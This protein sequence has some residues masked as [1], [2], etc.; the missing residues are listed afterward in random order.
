MFYHNHPCAITREIVRRGIKR[1]NLWSCPPCSFDPDLLI[2]AGLVERTYLAYVG[3]EHMGFAPFFRK[4]TENGEID[5]VLCDE[6]TL[7]GALMA[8]IE[9]IPYHP[10]T[11]LRGTDTARL[12]PLAQ[13]YVAPTGDKLMAVRAMSPD[14][15]VLLVTE[16]DEYGN[17]RHMGSV[18]MDLILAKAS[19][20]V[21]L[22][23]EQIV[24]HEKVLAE[25]HRTT[26]PAYLVDMVV[27][28]PWGAHPCSSHM[29]Y[30][31]DEDHMREYVESAKL[32]INGQDP[33]AFP[34]YLKK[35]IYEPR[36]HFDYL[37]AI[38]GVR[39]LAELRKTWG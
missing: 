14:V 2:G 27:E 34:N 23:V 38:G 10:V 15:A 35:Y 11:S 19:K 24:P 39:R 16:A 17:G 12:T 3:F 7:A 18:F 28:V 13:E 21:I 20:K 31:Q 25:P 8:T 26:I 32:T 36:D 4:A 37:E 5:A 33:Q 22:Q 1:L 6:S 30:I 29:C 9:G